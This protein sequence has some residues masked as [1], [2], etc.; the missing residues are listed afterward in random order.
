VTRDRHRSNALQERAEALRREGAW[1]DLRALLAEDCPPPEV[2]PDLPLFLAEAELRTGQVAGAR[3]RLAQLMPAYQV[4]ADAGRLRRALN[5]LG[6]AELEVGDVA[7]ADTA[8]QQALELANVAGDHLTVARVTNNLGALA[9]QRGERERALAL[10]RLAVPA[11]QRLGSDVGLAETYH[12]LAITYRDLG[13][14]DQAD[15]YQRRSIDHARAA[16]NARML[17]IAHVGRA[18]LSLLRGEPLVAEAG[19]R[20]GA[21]QYAAIP[22]ALGEADA[23]RLAGAASTTLGNLGAAEAALDRSVSLARAHGGALVEAESL[24]ARARLHALRREWGPT[25]EDGQAAVA[26]Y[27]RLHDERAGAVQDWLATAGIGEQP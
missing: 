21:T 8:F 26:L 19:A 27:T 9:N 1:G 25:V 7:A 10:Y 15:R 13:R 14:L 23:L 5:M 22:D 12:N 11:F 16:G 2:A 24:E 6:V 17:A 4:M 3:D 18:E 20:L